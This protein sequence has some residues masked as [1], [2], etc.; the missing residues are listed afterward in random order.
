MGKLE[1]LKEVELGRRYLVTTK[2]IIQ[3]FYFDVNAD[4]FWVE[5]SLL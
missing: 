3:G 2:K 4:A 1:V 5:V